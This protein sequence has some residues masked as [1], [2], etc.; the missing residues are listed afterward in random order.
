KPSLEIS[1]RAYLHEIS[2]GVWLEGIIIFPARSRKSIE[3]AGL[4]HH[5]LL[6]YEI[7]PRGRIFF[8]CDLSAYYSPLLVDY[9]YK[10]VMPLHLTTGTPCEVQIK[11]KKRFC[12]IFVMVAWE[13]FTV[14]L[15]PVGI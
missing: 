6:L 4:F 13:R 12:L 5:H 15:S 3:T 8:H 9:C 14:R 10:G 11:A 2:P 7:I 1:L